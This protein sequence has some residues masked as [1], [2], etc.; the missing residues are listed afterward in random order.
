MT[1]A[2]HVSGTDRLAEVA[3]KLELAAD[4]IVVNLQG[5]EPLIPPEVI[6][7][8]A[9]N[10]LAHPDCAAATLAQTITTRTE[11]LDPSAVKVV[12]DS[13]GRA[14]YFS[15]APIPWPRDLALADDLL[16]AAFQPRRHIGL[17]AYRA[18][19]LRQFV[20]WPEAP[21][22]HIERLEQLRILYQGYQIHLDSCCRPVPGG[23]DTPEDL[24]R[25]RTQLSV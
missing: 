24:H 10:L 13:Q 1:D 23:V 20:S 22:E 6:D 4:A 7:Q 17:Y 11:F 2:A 8:V 18:H 16:P 21:L 12:A 19:L 14:L 25:V 3:A 5:D 15:R 9:A